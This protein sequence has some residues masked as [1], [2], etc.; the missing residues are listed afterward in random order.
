MEQFSLYCKAYSVAELRRFPGWKTNPNSLRPA[1]SGEATARTLTEEDYLFLHDDFAVTDGVFRD[2][3]IVFD[4]ATEDWMRFCK[5]ELQF[6]I[7]DDVKA[8]LEDEE[9]TRAGS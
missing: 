7:P 5:E 9:G 1:D 4:S 2:E 6:A 3:Y 8:M